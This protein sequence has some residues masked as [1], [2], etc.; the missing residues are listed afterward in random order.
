M[1]IDVCATTCEA[2]YEDVSGTNFCR[3]KCDEKRVFDP[4]YDLH[5]CVAVCPPSHAFE[6]LDECVV[7]CPDEMFADAE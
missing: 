7:Q 3:D 2:F 6:L 4:D 5:R 1:I